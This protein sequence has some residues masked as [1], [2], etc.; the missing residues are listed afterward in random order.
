MKSPKPPFFWGVVAT[1]AVIA[2]FYAYAALMLVRHGGLVQDFGWSEGRRGEGW[3]VTSVEPGGRA[4]GKLR[5]GDGILAVNGDERVARVGPFFKLRANPV[6]SAYTV[7]VARGPEQ[8]EF[9]LEAPIHRDRRKLGE[10]LSLLPS[11][12]AFAVVGI[13][14]GVLRPRDRMPKL[15]VVASLPTSLMVLGMALAPLS[16]FFR[17]F[18]RF[19]FLALRAIPPFHVLLGYS[20]LYRFATSDT[21]QRLWGAIEV[22]LWAW[23][24][25]VFLP[26]A[27]WTLINLPDIA[28][29][30][31]I[32]FAHPGLAGIW[33]P[34]SLGVHAFAQFS[35]CG[36][37]AANYHRI[38]E[39]DH[40]RR[41]KW[42]VYGTA[43]SLFP[44]AA[45]SA[46]WS[47]Q[48]ASQPG[49]GAVGG[50]FAMVMRFA[51]AA[52]IG[53]PITFGYAIAKHRVLG[54]DVVVRR[55]LQY[56]LAH[57]VLRA[58]L[59]LPAAALG[60]TLVSHPERTIGEV[61]FGPSSYF[62]LF[63]LAAGSASLKYRRQIMDWLDR[64]FFREAYDREK[65]LL[66]LVENIKLCS[67]VKDVSRLVC[68]EVD[69]ALHPRTLH[70]YYR[71]S[72]R[73]DFMLQYSSGGERQG[74]SL[75]EDSPLIRIMEQRS[76][77][78]ELPLARNAD[79][80][81]R[82]QGWLREF[83]ASLVVPMRGSEQ[84]LAGLLLLGEKKSEEPYAA[85]DRKLLD[86]I[87]GQIAVVC[88]NLWLKERVER[89]LKVRREVLAHLEDGG[90]NLVRECPVCGACFDRAEEF[91]PQDR[92]ELIL[93]L[94]VE[95]TI[96][97]RYR[98][99]RLLGR[100]GMGA[101]YEATDL[102]LERKVAIKIMLGALFGHQDSLRRF[103]REARASAQ[104]SH[105]N[106][107]AVYDYGRTGADGAYLVMERLRGS[108]WRADLNRSG[109]VEPAVAAE[110]FDQVLSGLAAAHQA[111][112]IHRDLKP[113]NIML[114]SPA[115]GG[116]RVKILD[117]G[118]AKVRMLGVSGQET[119]TASLTVP[120][121]VL[122]TYMYMSPEQLAG[123]K[124]DER[125]DLFSLGIM[126][127]E[128][129]TGQRPFQGTSLMELHLAILQG[130]FH[131]KGEAKE[132]RRLD[133]VLQRSLSKDATA[134]FASAAAMQRELIPALRR[135]PR[136]A[137]PLAA[138]TN[139]AAGFETA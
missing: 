27:T 21:R 80:P 131:L 30:M 28:G 89:D 87:G 92:V 133:A 139:G 37:L 47:L 39:P 40:R 104:L 117:F 50:T 10:P 88:E 122:G 101:V 49:F 118:T 137:A 106:I 46:V 60:L 91:C 22:L 12:L 109:S 67:S 75:A 7:R 85:A 79:L 98:L 51:N 99:D 2:G 33:V 17:G 129:V 44:M 107:I 14:V 77:P 32:A 72:E 61:L 58:V 62:Y 55:G 56:L 90:I 113:E 18:E 63:I 59:L 103:E 83:G 48:A 57:N 73:G 54:V 36:V 111:G 64:K 102:R 42:I 81:E 126:V 65:V 110:W 86:G 74:I 19:P 100:G 41:L 8:L 4:E 11:S 5:T 105:R 76:G 127:V 112:V 108:T 20:F 128:T 84:R 52:T 130:S 16:V 29:A 119:G 34:L 136:L 24:A 23:G 15:L 138:S 31:D 114:T 69:S 6:T 124:V 13:L 123:G 120:G 95:R 115:E 45:A 93:T 1:A 35:I 125:T 70:L 71:P 38:T 26:V 66:A 68:Q 97:G 78:L 135:C 116:T 3:Y 53:I 134:R 82:E 94:P 96:E 132:V 121:T 25:A 43:A 9:K